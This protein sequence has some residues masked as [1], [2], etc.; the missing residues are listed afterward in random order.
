MDASRKQEIGVGILVIVAAALLAFMSIKVGGI[1]AIGDQIE[2]QVNLGDAAGL[3]EGAA[4]RV[5]G[6]QV[7]QVDTMRVDHNQARLTVSLGSSAQIRE[8]AKVQVR[9]RSVLGEKYLEI[10]PISRDTPLLKTGAT[11]SV[12]TPQTEIDELVNSLGPLVTAMDAEAMHQAMVK[13]GDELERDPDQLARMLGNIDTIINNGAKASAS[14]DGLMSETRSTL[15]SVRQVTSDARPIIQ[16]TGRIMERV[17]TA[18]EDLPQISSDVSAMVADAR[19]MI[20]DSHALMSR[21]ERSSVKLERVLDNVADLDKWELR[22][23]LREE[24]IL[25]RFKESTVDPDEKTAE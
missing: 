14:L 8:D 1:G 7:G 23:L 5:A 21:L 2:I 16:R 15:S 19:T 12:T 20:K 4:V 6:V 13:L 24:G 11:L 3:T 10:T 17:D 18:S 22:R 25:V 9:A